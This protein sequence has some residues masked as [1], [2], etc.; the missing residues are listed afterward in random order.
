MTS[1]V[2]WAALIACLA[3]T[4]WRFP[5]MLKGRNRGLFWIF[6]IISLCVGL[7][8]PAVYEP[9]DGLLG[10]INVANV[11]LRLGLFAVFFLLATRVAAAYNS[12]LAGKLVHGPVGLAVLA[13]C[14]L[15]I[16]I[17]FF[18]S[19]KGATSTGLSGLADEP[20]LAAYMWFGKAYMAY[21]AACIVVP[22]ARAAFSLRPVLDR[23]AALLICIGFVLVLATVPIQLF[24]DTSHPLQKLV[25]FSAILFVAAGL[26]LVWLSFIRRPKY[27]EARARALRRGTGDQPGGM[28]AK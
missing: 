4:V 7:S 8:V 5:A 28:Q 20:A 2:Q 10:G 27:P 15:G 14:S 13:I 18:L 12:P 6:A 24:P 21:A 26:S 22:T 11:L 17:S 25:S 1:I 16:W 19:E 9:V 3:C 23:A